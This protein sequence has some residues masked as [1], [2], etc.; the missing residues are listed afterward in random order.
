LFTQANHK[1]ID[2]TLKSLNLYEVSIESEHKTEAVLEL[3]EANPMLPGLVILEENQL[4]G[5]IS[6]QRFFEYMSRR[7]SLELFTKRPVKALYQFTKTD[8]L[9]LPIHTSIT[10]AM[11]QS[12]Q[13]DPKLI[14]EPIVVETE[15]GS[16]KI[17]DVHQLLI[18]EL[19]LH[20]IAIAAN[21]RMRKEL[22]QAKNQL[23]AVLDAVPGF[24]CWIGSNLHYLGVN[25][26]LAQAFNLSPEKFI[27]QEVG[28]L[29]A[30]PQFVEL[31]RKIFNSTST[32]MSQEINMK[33]DGEPKN[34]LIVAQKYNQDRGVVTVGI[35]ISDRKQLE[36]QLRASLEREKE[37]GE[38]KS[39]FVTMTSHEFRTPLSTIFSSVELL[40][41]YSHQWTE[42]KKHLHFNRIRNA[43]RHMIRILDGVLH[44]GKAEAGRLE[45]KPAPL[46][47]G[48]FCVDL[49]KELPSGDRE[50]V[51]INQCCDL[52]CC[53]DENLLRHILS[54]L[55]SNSIK[56]SPSGSKIKFEVS[57]Q[58]QQVVFE[59]QD[60]GIGIPPEDQQ[61]LFESFHRASNVGNIQGTGLGLA[62]VKRC[63]ALHGGEISVESQV[64][65]GTKFEV[66]IP[67]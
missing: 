45:F 32:T 30:S 37:L 15:S 22:E 33:V 58:N 61:H 57:C 3:F 14:Y 24:V 60:N 18:A 8:I 65:V 46:K 52:C 47:L 62:I 13:R 9:V 39:R 26:R 49:L 51:F 11:R 40:E 34:Y 67:Y 31:V 4:V 28:S 63:V 21:H 2:P 17:L 56:Y 29:G 7:Y 48:Q 35:D 50:I 16:Y 1:H 36:T 59:I 66:K 12:L 64:G 23:R 6:R 10:E 38:L 42:E 27:G 41:H 44:I 43:I 25:Q 53:L 5:T 19:E 54:N 55:I 20:Q